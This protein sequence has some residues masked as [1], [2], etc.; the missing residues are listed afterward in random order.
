MF[1]LLAALRL[2]LVEVSPTSW[3]PLAGPSRLTSASAH[4][5]QIVAQL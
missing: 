2:D 4:S 5:H 1:A 3:I